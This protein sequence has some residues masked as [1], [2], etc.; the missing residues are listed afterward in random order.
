MASWRLNAADMAVGVRS[1]A[2]VEPSMS[3]NSKVTSPC[4]GGTATLRAATSVVDGP[5]EGSVHARQRVGLDGL[6]HVALAGRE[7][8]HDG[9]RRWLLELLAG[10]LGGRD[11]AT[12]LRRVLA[13]GARFDAGRHVDTPRPHARDR[14]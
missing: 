6:E 10:T 12:Q 1:H 7:I 13:A 4:G 14:L 2:R 9:A 11:E 3:E 5:V 8:E